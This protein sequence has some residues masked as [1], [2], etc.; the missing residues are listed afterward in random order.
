MRLIPKNLPPTSYK[1]QAAFSMIEVILAS[2]IF[3]M[4]VVSFVG[5]FLYGQESTTL[6]GKRS[7]AVFL[8]EEGLEALKNIRDAGF[9][10][11][12]DGTFGLAISGGQWILSGVS[13]VNGIFTR[14]IMIS[15]IDAKR[16]LV[17]SRVDWQQNLQR[18]G[19]ISLASRLTNWI[20]T[21]M[22]NWAL[23]SLE[24]IFNFTAGNSGNAT[25]NSNAIAFAN[26]LV[27]LGRAN[28]GGREFFIFDVS[29]P[30]VPVLLGQRDLNGTPNDIVISGNYAYVASTDNSEELQIIDISDP[31]TIDQAGKLTSVNLTAANSGNATVNAIALAISGNYLLMIRAGG[32]EFLIFDLTNPSTPGNPVGRTPSLTGTVS[33]LA[34]AGDYAYVAS[35][36]NAAELQIVDITTKT[37]PARIQVFN[38][39]SGN[40]NADGLSLDVGNNHVFLGRAA[41]AAPEFYTINV[42][43][44]L[45]PALADTLELGANALAISLEPN[46][47]YVFLATADTA[48]DFKVIDVSNPAA[49]SLLG[50][51]NLA[52]GPVDVIYDLTLDRAFL[53]STADTE[54][55]QIVRT[56]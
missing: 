41:S 33:D 15:T 54:E 14:Q 49:I 31:A 42:A 16:K 34:T 46:S 10:N 3:A 6:A 11:L 39:N 24:A 36:D 18:T 22:G 45:T 44:P 20:A 19:T 52:N 12:T 23:P 55:L 17:T 38:L 1:L 8:A 48:N 9:A 47:G 37:A 7:S 5:V 56:Q 28:S 13:D 2:S 21:A 25:A 29:N 4:I 32:D 35:T 50:Q 53:A 43:N 30:A 27:Y 26:N 51:L 40:A